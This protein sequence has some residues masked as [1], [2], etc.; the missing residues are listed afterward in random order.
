MIALVVDVCPVPPLATGKVPV[1]FVVKSMVPFAIFA[2][3]TA[4]EFIFG[5]VIALSA[6]PLVVICVAKMGAQNI[7]NRILEITVIVVPFV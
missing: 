3:V 5:A 4:L 2:F 7:A 6:I 1:T